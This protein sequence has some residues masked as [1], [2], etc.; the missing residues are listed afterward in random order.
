[1]KRT[2]QQP[3][4][5]IAPNRDLLRDHFPSGRVRLSGPVRGLVLTCFSLLVAGILLT[6]SRTMAE[7]SEQFANLNARTIRSS[8]SQSSHHHPGYVDPGCPKHINESV[9]FAK[10]DVPEN[11]LRH[12]VSDGYFR[13]TASHRITGTNSFHLVNL[14]L[15]AVQSAELNSQQIRDT[16]SQ[17]MQHQD[18]RPV[19]RRVL[20]N[21]NEDNRSLRDGF[22]IRTLTRMAEAI[23]DFMEW[24]LSGLFR[25]RGA[26]R[27]GQPANPSA[28]PPPASTGG[29]IDFS[30]G[31][32]LLYIG[33]AALVVSTIW[34]IATIIKR[35]DGR[36]KLDSSGLFDDATGLGDLSIPPGELAAST[37]ESRAINMAREGNYRGAIRE[38]LIGSMSWIERAGLIRFRKGLTNRDYIRAVWRQED[39]RIAYGTTAIEFER[40]YFG[41]RPATRRMFEDCLQSFQGA[42]REEETTTAAV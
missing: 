20:E 13:E 41:R 29:G 40:I 5:S 36:R 33:L 34:I 8:L 18:Y 11:G 28:P 38:L 24:I 12:R 21:I 14:P 7:Y 3:S 35:K 6:G 27:Q 42:F 4:K 23:G 39:R 17:V 31:S 32:V 30:L 10:R 22:L 2:A 26:P 16:A 25:S 1:M 19:R 15:P 37:Y 9:E